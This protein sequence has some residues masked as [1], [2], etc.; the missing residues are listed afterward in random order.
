[1][2]TVLIVSMLSLTTIFSIYEINSKIRE[3]TEIGL[4]N[5]AVA[6]SYDP[7]ISYHIGLP[8]GA[9]V[10]DPYVNEIRERTGV[11]YIVVTDMKGIRYS[12]CLPERIGKP[13]SNNSIKRAIATGDVYT[14][15]S[16]GTLGLTVKAFAPIFRDHQQVGVVV[17][18]T[19]KGNIL[20]EYASFIV[21]LIP[22]MLGISL[23]GYI[24]AKQLAKSIKK[25]IYGLEP[26]EIALLLKEREVILD[27]ITDGLI[28]VNSE[29]VISVINEYAKN[30]LELEADL[31]GMSLQCLHPKMERYFN[32]VINSEKDFLN[33]EQKLNEQLKIMSNYSVIVE[34]KEVV[35]AILTFKNMSDIELLIEELAGVKDLNWDLRAQNHEFM[36]KLQT[37]SGL[38]QL[39]E[40][41]EALHYIQ[42]ITEKRNEMIACLEQIKEV[43]ISALILGKYNRASEAKIKFSIDPNTSLTNLPSDLTG[44]EFGCVIGNLLEN[45]IEAL[46]GQQD[47]EIYLSIV[48]EEAKVVITIINNGPKIEEELRDKIF[49]RGLSTKGDNR[50]LGL[51]NVMQILTEVNG[52]LYLESTEEET[53]WVVE[54]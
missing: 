49:E 16:V 53:V 46:R 8:S 47:G 42:D 10:I 37:I 20:K 28:A 45:S 48:E 24:G 1:M 38:I 50:G 39:E 6:L 7:M 54:V 9:E 29:G 34:K 35:G 27:N 17:V 44:V 25:T 18:G 11:T 19:L 40:Y 15:E 31:V 30:L 12:H 4:T 26:T 33:V 51:S 43:S 22:V 23:I 41:D 13:F 5:M 2:V 14:Y 32:K 52:R 3:K 21:V 36:N